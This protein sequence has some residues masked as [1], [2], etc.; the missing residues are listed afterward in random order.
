MLFSCA[1]NKLSHECNLIVIFHL[2]T[3]GEVI[4]LNS[5]CQNTD[6]LFESDTDTKKRKTAGLTS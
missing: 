4:R 3:K 1:V 5:V 6:Q 2:L